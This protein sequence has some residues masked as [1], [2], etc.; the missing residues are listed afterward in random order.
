MKRII[1]GKTY[2][3]ETAEHILTNTSG[4]L[5]GDAYYR[6][7]TLYRTKRGAYFLHVE[8]GGYTELGDPVP[9]SHMTFNSGQKIV[10]MAADEAREWLKQHGAID[11]LEGVGP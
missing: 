9:K 10:P 3:T 1:G 7:E 8:G 11:V 2:N 6:C 5:R 4:L